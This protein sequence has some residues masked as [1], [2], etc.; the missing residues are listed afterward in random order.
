M[1]TKTPP[2]TRSSDLF[3]DIYL[4]DEDDKRP[5]RFRFETQDDG[6]FTMIDVHD[7]PDN[8]QDFYSIQLSGHHQ[9]QFTVAV[10]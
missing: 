8:D 2:P 5:V 3:D 7:R 9:L 6:E 1:P 10:S 4:A